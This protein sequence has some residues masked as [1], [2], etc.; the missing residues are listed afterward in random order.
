MTLKPTIEFVNHASVLVQHDGIGV[1]SDPWFFGS[2]FHQGW[3]LLHETPDEEVRDLLKRTTH[4]WLSH[5]HPD[6]FSPPFFM[7]FR[8]E[9]LAQGIVILFQTTDDGRVTEFL[10][11]KGFSVREIPEAETLALAPDFKLQIYK[12]DLYDSALLMEVAGQKIFNLNDCPLHEQKDLDD[13]VARY[14]TCDLLLTQFSYAAWKGGRD[15]ADWRRRAAGSKL[16][17]MKKQIAALQPKVCLPFAS[18]V[19]FSNTLNAYMN[20][21]VNSPQKVLAAFEREKTP[22]LF[23]KP[24]E[25]QEL[26]ALKPDQQSVAWW[27]ERFE[28]VSELPLTEFEEHFEVADLRRSYQLYQQRI[29]RQNSKSIMW[30]ANK[31]LP[32]KPFGVTHV[33]LLDQQ[34]TVRIEMLGDLQESSEFPDVEMHSASLDFLFKNDFG[35]DT[36]FVNGCFEEAFED[37]FSRFAKCFA[38]GNL[39]AMGLSVRFSLLFRLEVIRLLLQ[40]MKTVRNNMHGSAKNRGD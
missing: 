29:F 24:A 35:L 22:L 8:D 17:V 2:V 40:K 36:L 5:E 6:H 16:T 32:L 14:G 11:G 12:S 28:A 18:F 34:K 26:T 33:R 31:L 20:D 15:R 30:L 27:Q 23:M 7:K 4:I 10:R 3:S 1:L 9:I 25:V 37:G 39:N 13:F 38:V 21:E 19:Y